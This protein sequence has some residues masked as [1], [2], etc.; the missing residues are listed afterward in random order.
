MDSLRRCPKCGR[1]K[2]KKEF[3]RLAMENL[4]PEEFMYC[5]QCVKYN[6]EKD[7]GLNRIIEERLRHHKT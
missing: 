6:K 2:S 5:N 4:L 1:F 3:I 7:D